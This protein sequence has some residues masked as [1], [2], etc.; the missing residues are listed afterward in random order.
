MKRLG[1][2]ML[3]LLLYVITDLNTVY[4]VD[5]VAMFSTCPVRYPPPNF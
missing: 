2:V 1:S 3:F 5:S 4:G